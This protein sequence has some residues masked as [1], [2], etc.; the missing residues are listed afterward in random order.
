MFI[1]RK[2]K[3]FQKIRESHGGF[4]F[5]ISFQIGDFR[6]AQSHV[7]LSMTSAK[8]AHVYIILLCAVTMNHSFEFFET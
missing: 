6:H 8:F 4:K 2:R 1:Q 7:Q 5:L 3:K